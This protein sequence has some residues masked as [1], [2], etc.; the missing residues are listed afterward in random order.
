MLVAGRGNQMTA[1]LE[2]VSGLLHEAGETHHRVYRIEWNY[3]T[4]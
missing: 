3:W 4:E 1:P 2:Q